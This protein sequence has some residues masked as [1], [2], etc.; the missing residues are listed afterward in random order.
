MKKSAVFDTEA[1]NMI[2]KMLIGLFTTSL[3]FL[4]AVP[5]VNGSIVIEPPGST[6]E[7][8]T[9]GGW[10]AEWWQWALSQSIPNDAFI[11]ANASVGQAGPVFYIAGTTGGSAARSF[12]VPGDKFLLV[13]LINILVPGLASDEAD[14][15]ADAAS[16]IDSV[17]SLFA[18]IDGIAVPESDLFSHRELSPLFGFVAA[19]DN[20]FGF[21]PGPSDGVSDGYWLMLDPL[22]MGVH[23]ISFGG[24]T[25][26]GFTL[27]VTDTVTAT[28]VPEPSTIL[29]LG[30]GLVGVG[31]LK[32]R[33]KK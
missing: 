6:V 14:L 27:D 32:R 30:A 19:P 3:L 2:G 26:S 9:I 16:F 33:S 12:T 1:M 31:L 15:R 29:L 7:G 21:P 28:A 17:D 24:A 25:S 5:A 20:P 4:V 22:G 8:N 10:T 13:P 18:T 11:G 23:T